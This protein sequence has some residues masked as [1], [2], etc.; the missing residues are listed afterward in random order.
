MYTSDSSKLFLLPRGQASQDVCRSALVAGS[1]LILPAGQTLQAVEREED[2]NF[3]ATHTLQEDE[4]AVSEYD[5]AAQSVQVE[6]EEA[7]RVSLNV[8][9]TQSEQSDEES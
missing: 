5:P 1:T 6:E 4:A 3:P 8:P 9:T 7:P 2:T